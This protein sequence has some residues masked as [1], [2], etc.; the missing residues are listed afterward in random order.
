M[1]HNILIQNDDKYCS[2]LL[3]LLVDSELNVSIKR[4]YKNRNDFYLVRENSLLSICNFFLSPVRKY[5]YLEK[6][7]MN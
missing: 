5:N 3:C 6:F 2:Q 1:S 4:V 7:G